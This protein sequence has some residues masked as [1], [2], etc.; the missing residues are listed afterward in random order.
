VGRKEGRKVEGQKG[1]KEGHGRKEGGKEGREGRRIEGR[2]GFDE[3]G[4]NKD[5][6]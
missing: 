2:I 1:R 5:G 6:C 3:V 4:C